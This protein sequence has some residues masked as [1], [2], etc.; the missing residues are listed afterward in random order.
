MTTRFDLEQQ[1][2]DCWKVVDDIKTISDHVGESPEFEELKPEHE[3]QIL[4]LLI[5]MEKLYQLKF[6]KM[7]RT[8]EALIHNR[9]DM[10]RDHLNVFDQETKPKRVTRVEVIDGN[11]RSYTN[12]CI[13]GLELSYQDNGRTLKLFIEEETNTETKEA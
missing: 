6:E 11:G 12:S 8:F 7:F 13:T 5:G 10:P 9:R 2:M 4:N 1:I 3:D